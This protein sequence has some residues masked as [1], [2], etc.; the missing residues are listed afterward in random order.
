MWYVYA[1]EKGRKILD[2][3]AGFWWFP[4]ALFVCKNDRTV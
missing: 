3:G 1:Q 4:L 2:K